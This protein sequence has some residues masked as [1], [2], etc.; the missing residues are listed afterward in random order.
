MPAN[1]WIKVRLNEPMPIGH[2]VDT[3][4]HDGYEAIG[5]MGEDVVW[6]EVDMYRHH[7]PTRIEIT[8]TN[9]DHPRQE[10]YTDDE[11]EDWIA[12]CARTFTPEEFRGAMKFTIGKYKRRLGKK[13]EIVQEVTKVADYSHRWMEYETKLLE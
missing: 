13:D 7:I 5:I 11:G 9:R 8:D 6:R 12:E 3:I 10:R 2:K 1:L 4:R